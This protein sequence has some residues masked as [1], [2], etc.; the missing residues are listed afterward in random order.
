MVGATEWEVEKCPSC[1]EVGEERDGLLSGIIEGDVTKDPVF[2]V[3]EMTGTLVRTEIRP[4]T[5]GREAAICCCSLLR[6]EVETG[7]DASPPPSQPHASRLVVCSHRLRPTPG[8]RAGVRSSATPCIP[9]GSVDEDA[10]D[11]RPS[12]VSWV[13]AGSWMKAVQVNGDAPTDGTWEP[14]KSGAFPDG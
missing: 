8:G 4:G 6:R 13:D 12:L 2:H 7:E 1:E 5:P 14:G 10:V 3:V 11:L 9:P